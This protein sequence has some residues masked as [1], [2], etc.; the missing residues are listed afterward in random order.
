MISKKEARYV[1]VSQYVEKC[2][3]CSM[4]RAGGKCTLVKGAIK[5]GGWCRYW[6]GKKK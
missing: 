3:T 1:D 6:E 4:Y 2:S 5:P